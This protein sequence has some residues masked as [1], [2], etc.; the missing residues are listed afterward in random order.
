M[1]NKRFL[2]SATLF[3]L[4]TLLVA[5]LSWVGSIY[6]WSGVQ[7]LISAEGLRWKLR[8]VGDGLLAAPFFGDLLLLSFGVGLCLHSGFWETVKG[9]LCRGRK[10]SRKELRSLWLSLTVGMVYVLAVLFLVLDPWGM[11]R[12]ITGGLKGSPLSEGISYLLSLGLGIVAVI[13]GYT[14][15]LYRTDRDIIKGMSYGSVRFS[16]YCVTLF[17][18]VQFF[19]SLRYTGLDVFFGLSPVCFQVLYTICCILPLFLR[20]S[21]F[22]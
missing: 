14:V 17:F 6:G 10:L 12:S 8:N 11:V 18:V 19:T 1:T 4:L 7:N 5:L 22:G 9:G 13:Y 20:K 2:H 21:N 3:F 15:D 16:G